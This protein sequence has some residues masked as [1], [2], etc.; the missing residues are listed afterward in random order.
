MIPF[1]RMHIAQSVINRISNTLEEVGPLG[2]SNKKPAAP[3]AQEPPIP[4]NP[5][6]EGMQIDNRL[7]SMPPPVAVPPEQ[8]TDVNS[9]MLETSAMG[10]SPFDGA[11]L[12]AGGSL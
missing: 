1:P 2:M 12:G 6:V 8:E 3:V 5:S 11:L 10:G 9:A 4:P 7:K